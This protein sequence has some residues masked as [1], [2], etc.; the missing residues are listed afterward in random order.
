MSEDDLIE[1]LPFQVKRPRTD[2]LGEA[3]LGVLDHDRHADTGEASHH[4]LH[5]PGEITLNQVISQK[6][7]FVLPTTNQNGAYDWALLQGPISSALDAMIK[8]SEVE[9]S[10]LKE[11]FLC[12]LQKIELLLDE[13]KTLADQTSDH[14]YKTQRKKIQSLYTDI[15]L[16][17][18]RLVQEISYLVEKSDIEE[19]LVREMEKARDQ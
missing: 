15:E 17:E 4:L 6:D 1:S 2:L 3:R 12:R 5:L 14:H 11:D 10:Q 13:I 16:D 19:E 8:M 9:G 18:A 7:I